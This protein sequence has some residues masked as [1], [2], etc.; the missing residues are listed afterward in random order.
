MIFETVIHNVNDKLPAN[1]TYVL[2]R[3]TGGNWHDRDH[4]EGCVWVVAK[5]TRGISI[6]EREDMPDDVTERDTPRNKIIKSEDEYGNNTKAYSWSEFGP[7]TLFGQEVDLWM[8]LPKI[9][10]EV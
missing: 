1:N 5:F 9:K 3:Y 7:S 6:K 2:A 10:G 8:D 4:Q